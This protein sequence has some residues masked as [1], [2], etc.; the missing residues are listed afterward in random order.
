MVSASGYLPL[1]RS[2]LSYWITTRNVFGGPA[3]RR[4]ALRRLQASRPEPTQAPPD[5]RRPGEQPCGKLITRGHQRCR[6]T[7]STWQS[8]K[9]KWSIAIS[10]RVGQLGAERLWSSAPCRGGC[11]PPVWPRWNLQ[12]VHLSPTR[13]LSPAERERLLEPPSGRRR[14]ETQ[15][16]TRLV[17]FGSRP[18]SA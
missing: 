16:A 5:T 7:G 13:R 8:I 9:P 10:R 12:L 11:R 3:W 1:N 2:W 17:S 14:I 6:T 18:N 4:C 15:T